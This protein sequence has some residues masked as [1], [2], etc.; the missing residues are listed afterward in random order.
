MMVRRTPATC[1]HLKQD[2]LGSNTL[3]QRIT[4]RDCKR[5]LFQ[6]W[7]QNLDSDL[8]EQCMGKAGWIA[9]PHSRPLPRCRCWRWMKYLILLLL[10]LLAFLAG[11]SVPKATPARMLALPDKRQSLPVSKRRRRRP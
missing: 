11:T 3:Q 6:I 8:V 10:L 7:P 9:I 4:C 1:L 5:V 2:R